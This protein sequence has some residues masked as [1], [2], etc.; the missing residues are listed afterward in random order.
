MSPFIKGDTGGF[1]PPQSS[2]PLTKGRVR[3]GIITV[4][5]KRS[6][7]TKGM[8]PLSTKEAGGNQDFGEKK[9]AAGEKKAAASME[10]GLNL[11]NL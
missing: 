5:V 3:E 6:P 10:R 9:E 7:L 11:L 4:L 2:P 1:C 8:V